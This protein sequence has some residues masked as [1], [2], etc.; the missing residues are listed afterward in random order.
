[1]RTKFLYAAYGWLWVSGILHFGLDVI[2]QYVRGKRAPGREATLYYGLNT[3]YTFGQV[4]VAILAL[5]AILQGVVATGQWP[6]LSIGFGAALAW[7]TIEY[8]QPKG[9]SCV[10]AV[11]LAGASLTT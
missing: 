7:L 9:V 2:S 10:S 6:G 4:L 3:T 5:F 1:M 11:L 8:L